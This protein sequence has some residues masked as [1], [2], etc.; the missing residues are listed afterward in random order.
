MNF[1]L[2]AA[3]QNENPPLFGA[4]PEIFAFFAIFLASASAFRVKILL[5]VCVKVVE[6]KSKV[7]ILIQRG[8]FYPF[9][10]PSL[11]IYKLSFFTISYWFLSLIR[12]WVVGGRFVE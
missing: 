2:F 11:P 4:R 1:R 6:Y 12:R 5:V 3:A 9:F 10:I 8:N 7:G